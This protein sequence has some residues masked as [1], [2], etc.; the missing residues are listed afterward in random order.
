[1]AEDLEPAKRVRGT[2]DGKLLRGDI[3]GGGFLLSQ[4]NRIP[5]G[6]KPS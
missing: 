2:V 6:G 5:A 1:M 4:L 3:R